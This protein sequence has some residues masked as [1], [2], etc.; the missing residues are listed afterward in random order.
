MREIG[1]AQL[2]HYPTQDRIVRA[3]SRLVAPPA[4]GKP[5]VVLDAGCGVGAAIGDLRDH[6]DAHAYVH[7]LGVEADRT[8]AQRAQERFD[9][10]PTGGACLWSD[11]EDTS[12]SSHVSMLWFNPPY[13][14]V[15]GNGRMETILFE[16]VRAWAAPET[17]IL[18]AILPDYVLCDPN[19]G[20]GSLLDRHYA[21][22]NVWR[23]PEPEYQQFKQSV[24]I[25]RRRKMARSNQRV[26]HPMALDKPERWAVLPDDGTP[27]ATLTAQSVPSLRRTRL[28]RELMLDV[29]ERS[30]LRSTLLRETTTASPPVARP[31][32]PLKPG[33]LA[34]ALAGG[35]CDRVIEA[36][37]CRFLLKGSLASKILKVKTRPRLTEEGEQIGVVDHWRT[38]HVVTVRC[39]KEDGQI[40][41]HSSNDGQEELDA[42][43]VDGE[44]PAEKED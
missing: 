37:G 12:I 1:R 35:L 9:S 44:D 15:R 29:L 8:R 20:F 38:V 41:T 14:V 11:I 6:W 5:A 32:L 7:L 16:H 40:E 19:A 3:I 39:L 22:L 10:H 36:H 25:A 27:V 42:V 18:V 4:D 17:G 34:L 2:G 31:L 43:S 28:S 26:P 21:I 24:L 30:P 13:D 23:Y 33:H